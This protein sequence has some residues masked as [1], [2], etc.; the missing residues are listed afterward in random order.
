MKITL[1]KKWD[2]AKQ[3]YVPDQPTLEGDGLIEI[4]YEFMNDLDPDFGHME[5]GT[6]I[7]LGPYRLEVVAQS[8]SITGSYLCKLLS[9]GVR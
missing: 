9:K 7:V 5:D 8:R 3:K 2:E 6:H 1:S 4:S